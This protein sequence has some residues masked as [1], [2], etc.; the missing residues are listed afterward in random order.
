[1]YE[2]SHDGVPV[3]FDGEMDVESGTLCYREKR[4]GNL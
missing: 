2:V 1:M 3:D 4:K